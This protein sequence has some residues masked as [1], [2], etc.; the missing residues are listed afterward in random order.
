MLYSPSIPTIILLTL[1]SIHSNPL[2]L[3]T[4]EYTK[5]TCVS[6]SALL[7]STFLHK[8]CVVRFVSQY[9]AF[10]AIQ[11]LFCVPSAI[12]CI[13]FIPSVILCIS[14]VLSCILS[15]ISRILIVVPYIL[16]VVSC[17]LS[18]VSYIIS[19]IS[20]ILYAVACNLTLTIRLKIALIPSVMDLKLN[21]KLNLIDFM[22][23]SL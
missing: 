9:Y 22:T 8:L 15:V 21:L 7:S 1:C 19:G 10:C 3:E 14:Y 17:I 2:Q 16:S 20:F 13:L 23:Y 6:F 4:R 12:A 18:L 11:R 5:C